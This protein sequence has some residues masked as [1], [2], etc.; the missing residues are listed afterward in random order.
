MSLGALAVH[1]EGGTPEMATFAKVRSLSSAVVLT[2]VLALSFAGA[3]VAHAAPHKTKPA[4]PLGNC[5]W[6][7][8]YQAGGSLYIAGGGPLVGFYNVQVQ[9]DTC[10]S[11]LHRAVGEM[12]AVYP[13]CSN[14]FF[15]NIELYAR[16]TS[17]EGTGGEGGQ[18][19]NSSCSLGNYLF[20]TTGEYTS[21]TQGIYC[22]AMTGNGSHFGPT[23]LTQY[24]TGN[25]CP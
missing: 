20:A 15:S 9:I 6:L 5:S 24:R 1:P 16:G 2:L 8:Q 11:T 4:V 17:V 10:N 21:S 7:I 13:A 14:A 12:E 18:I 19:D 23:Y 25:D 3:G 22:A